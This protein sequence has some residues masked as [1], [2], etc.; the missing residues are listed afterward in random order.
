MKLAILASP[1]VIYPVIALADSTSDM[2]MASRTICCLTMNRAPVLSMATRL[3]RNTPLDV[4]ALDRMP[5]AVSTD[6]TTRSG[7][8]LGQPG[9]QSL[10]FSFWIFA[11]ICGQ[12]DCLPHAAARTSFGFRGRSG[13]RTLGRGS[14]F[15]VKNALRPGWTFVAGGQWVARGLSPRITCNP[16]WHFN[17]APSSVDHGCMNDSPHHT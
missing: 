10:D 17:G 6:R 9:P 11:A 3:P 12:R 16:G 13:V 4:L 8:Q 14:G 7:F 15:L 1:L 5:S 2:S